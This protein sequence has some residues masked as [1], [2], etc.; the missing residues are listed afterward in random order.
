MLPPVDRCPILCE[1][2]LK[3]CKSYYYNYC[4]F[5]NVQKDFIVQ[6]GDPTDSGEGGSSV[7]Y[8][9]DQQ[10]RQP[11]GISRL[12][13]PEKHPAN[14]HT[15][16]GTISMACAGVDGGCG[17]IFFLT[18]TDNASYLDGKHAPFGKCVEEDSIATLEKFNT[19]VLLDDN[20]RPLRDVRIRHVVV[21][22]DPFPDPE[23]LVVPPNSPP[24]TAA[25][26]PPS[27]IW[28][29]VDP[30]QLTPFIIT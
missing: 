11:K 18:L 26:R 19:E 28:S 3:L 21:L 12:F 9:I 24:P 4:A 2:F 29:P 1:N 20:G 22:D 10:S 6:T 14:K 13:K 17:S 30:S 23:G 7:W 8:N 16:M 5:F 25:Q 15:A 27:S